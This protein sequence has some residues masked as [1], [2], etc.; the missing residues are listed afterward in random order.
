MHFSKK[1]DE[2]LKNAHSNKKIEEY[3]K[4]R[5]LRTK[6]SPFDNYRIR[7]MGH[8]VKKEP[9]LGDVLDIGSNI[10]AMAKYYSDKARKIVLCDLDSFVVKGAR[11]VNPDIKD[12]D[13]ISGNIKQLPFKDNQFD[14][15]VSL[16]TIEHVYENEQEDVVKEIIRVAKSGATIYLSTPNRLSAAGLEGKLIGLFKKGYQWDAWDN[17]HKYI[18]RAWDFEKFLKK[19]DK[20]IEVKSIFGSY[21]LPGSIVVRMP[22]FI[23]RFLGFM[24]YIIARTIGNI[25]PIKY[26]GF[27]TIAVLKKK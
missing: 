26:M 13:L 17:D 5:Q 3:V 9:Y 23:Q 6:T 14:T 7:L 1:L 21:F 10:G 27:T 24:S 11:I 20:E 4:I 19:F 16:E 25:F 22:L 12:L 15:V 8:L 18:Y 2:K